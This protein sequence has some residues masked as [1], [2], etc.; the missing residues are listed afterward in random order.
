MAR[1]RQ[2]GLTD[3]ETEIMDVVWTLGEATVEEVRQRLE[4][5]LADSTV[6]TMMAIMERK[7]YVRSRMEGR[8][9][10]YKARVQ[11]EQAQSSALRTLTRR[12]FAGSPDQLV[13]RLI[14]DEQ[15]TVEELDRLR[16]SLRRP[17]EGD[18]A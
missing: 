8:A 3:R 2:E 18:D 17:E 7:G 6:R 14:E 10:A 13:A 12:L 16:D 9:R 1:K 15:L 4:G 11:R 5:D